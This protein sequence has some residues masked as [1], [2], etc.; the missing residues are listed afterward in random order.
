MAPSAWWPVGG[1]LAVATVLAL[2]Q[3][4]APRFGASHEHLPSTFSGWNR[5]DG[6][7]YLRIASEGYGYQNGTL[8]FVAW[9]P[10]YP[11][12]VR[13]LDLVIHELL[14]AAVVVSATSGLIATVLYWRWLGGDTRRLGLD[15]RSKLLALGMAL[16]YPY[17]WFPYGVPYSDSLFLCCAVAAFLL[18]ESDRPALAGC[19]AAIATAT[20]VNGLALVVGL[21]MVVLERDG[22]LSYVE[23]SAPRWA[24]RFRVPTRLDLHRIRRHNMWVLLSLTGVVAFMV[25][26]D[27][28][29]GDPLAFYEAQSYWNHGPDR[30]W[31]SVL[32]VDWLGGLWHWTNPH[33]TA[34]STAQAVLTGGALLAI[35]FA[36]R[37]FGWGYAMFI[38]CTVAMVIASSADFLGAGRYLMSLFPLAALSGEWCGRRRPVT[39]A[40]VLLTCGLT[41][42]GLN[43]AWSRNVYLT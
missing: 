39:A 41:L 17:G 29:F 1:W 33:I 32:K 37:R 4:L 11:L 16:L 36:G 21:V 9:F 22:V 31:T 14:V 23:S 30:G 3:Y 2:A 13:G 24:R 38:G 10:A 27:L 19:V 25:Y 40:L 42:V 43:V 8:P 7:A 20:R 34:T 28:E 12:L 35:P 18:L 5:Y 6:P 26:L 15:P